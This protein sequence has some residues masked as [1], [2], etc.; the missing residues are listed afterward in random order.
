[1]LRVVEDHLPAAESE[2]RRR[3]RPRKG[4]SKATKKVKRLARQKSMR[5]AKALRQ[6]DMS[7]TGVP[8]TSVVTAANVHDSQVTHPYSLMDSAYDAAEIRGW[9]AACGRKAIIEPNRR[10][11]TDTEVMDPATRKRFAI[12]ST[13]ERSNAHLKDWLLPSK[14]LVKGHRKVSFCL[15]CGVVSLAAI[16]TLQQ[17]MLPQL[18]AAA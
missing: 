2:Y 15:M 1:M 3:G 4:E 17:I 16:K 8:L 9:I 14:L 10:G 12:R 6:L 7:D 18:E 11:S 13:V 5:A